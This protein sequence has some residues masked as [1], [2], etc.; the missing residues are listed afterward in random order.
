MVQ[1]THTSDSL[2][3]V[4]VTLVGLLVTE[5]KEVVVVPFSLLFLEIWNGRIDAIGASEEIVSTYTYLLK[6]YSE[7][8]TKM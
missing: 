4:N 7:S 2:T 5:V 1:C 3:S 8:V 6:P